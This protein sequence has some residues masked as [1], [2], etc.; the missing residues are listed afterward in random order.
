MV[1]SCD[2]I[3]ICPLNWGLGHAT[4]DIPII[5]RFIEKGFRVIV[6]TEDPI[7]QLLHK[8]IPTIETEYFP[9]AKI[10]YSSGNIQIWKL[11]KQ[12]PAALLWLVREKQITARL[13]KKY[14]P[15]CI[16]SDNRYGVRHN[17]VRSI[18][19]THQLMLKMP[20]GSRW[21]EKLFHLLAKTLISRFSFCWIPDNPPPNS[22]AGDLV[23]QYK[24]PK[25]G[26]LIGPMSRFMEK[27]VEQS[28]HKHK[29]C[30]KAELLILLSGPEPQRTILQNILV[31]K[32]TKEK[33]TTIMV[34]GKPGS[35]KDTSINN[36]WIEQY[37][38]I[39][40]VKLLTFIKETP[41]IICRSGYS[42]IM[43]FWFLN[44]LAVLIP[45]PGQ[46]EQEYLAEIHNKRSHIMIPQ[47][48]LIEQPIRDIFLIH[49]NTAINNSININPYKLLDFAIELI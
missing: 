16:I 26:V 24:I 30:S 46:T 2:T 6:A 19:I 25:N 33:I 39:E 7:I 13:V 18:I 49:R 20:P 5:K 34:T 41:N 12:L 17:K 28:D 48:K 14:N 27:P 21:L 37:T 38:H 35:N 36:E 11:L 3:L 22:L 43:D 23:H 10:S 4:R 47:N 44:K 32:I 42:S 9:G 40:T 29:P 1:N 31:K 8:E 15:V 45:T